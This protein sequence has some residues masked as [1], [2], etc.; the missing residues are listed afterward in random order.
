MLVHFNFDGSNTSQKSWDQKTGKVSGTN[1][2]KK[3]LEEHL[4]TSTANT[5]GEKK[6]PAKLNC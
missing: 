2:N 3:M 6:N 1:N 4:A 5:W